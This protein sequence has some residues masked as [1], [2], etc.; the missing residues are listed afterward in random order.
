VATLERM[1]YRSTGTGRT[2]SLLNLAVILA[3]S[4]RNNARDGLTGAL[5]A[6]DGQFIQVLEGS[7]DGLDRLLTRLESD[8]RHRD[9]VVLDRR[10]LEARLFDGWTMANARIDPALAPRLDSLMRQ[11]APE[12]DDIV[13]MI[14]GSITV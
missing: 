8:P 5:A 7:P 10:P 9:I 1:L 3:E 11:D 2:D 6:H 13:A 14:R 4:Q 12:L